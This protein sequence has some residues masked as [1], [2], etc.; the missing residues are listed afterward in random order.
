MTELVAK[1]PGCALDRAH[2]EGDRRRGG[3]KVGRPMLCLVAKQDDLEDLDGDVLGVW[4]PWMSE[5][6]RAV[7]SISGTTASTAE[8]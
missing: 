7:R 5:C 1:P 8:P 6:C 2:D 4:A 3:R